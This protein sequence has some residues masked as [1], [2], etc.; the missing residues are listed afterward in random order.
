MFKRKKDYPQNGK[1]RKRIINANRLNKMFVLRNSLPNA[2]RT[3]RLLK[4]SLLLV[5]VLA[6][7]YVF[8][9]FSISRE[10]FNPGSVGVKAVN[11][12]YN[13]T[14]L[15]QIEKQLDD[16]KSITTESVYDKIAIVNANKALNT[17]LKFGGKKDG[18]VMESKV[19]IINSQPGLVHYTI[20]SDALSEGRQFLFIYKVNWFGKISYV[21]EMEGIGF[22]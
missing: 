17:Y 21:N 11:Y 16:L 20:H 22:Y 14:N 4:S 7:L 18:D 12:L 8:V 9:G 19:E 13:F 1:L 5:F 3:E 2:S 15:E 10:L 6:L